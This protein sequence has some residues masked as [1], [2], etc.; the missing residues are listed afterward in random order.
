MFITVSF[1][2]HAG[3]LDKNHTELCM[4]GWWY[5]SKLS[6]RHHRIRN[7]YLS[8]SMLGTIILCS[9]PSSESDRA[10]DLEH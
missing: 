4:I 6:T 7:E 10:T 8:I 9:A 1:V 5:L 2:L 3:V